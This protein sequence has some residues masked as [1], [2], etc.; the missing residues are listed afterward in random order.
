MVIMLSQEL[1]SAK[2]LRVSLENA[3]SSASMIILTSC[4]VS[5][6]KKEDNETL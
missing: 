2:V 5:E 1:N 3:T 4:V 6:E